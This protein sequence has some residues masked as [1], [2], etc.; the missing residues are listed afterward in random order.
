[1][2]KKMHA[3]EVNTDVYLVGRMLREQFPQWADLSIEPVSTAGTDNAL[4]RL[5]DDLV[6]RLPRTEKSAEQ[7][8][9]EQQWLP[10]LAQHLPLA[11]PVPLAKG[12]PTQDYPW[13]WSV[14]PWLE[15]E[16]ATLDRITDPSQAAI[17]MAHFIMALQQ[18]DATD[19]P[20]PG[21]H[22]F[23]RGEPLANRD[24]KTREAIA[25]LN[26]KID[27]DA[28]TMVWEAALQ[29]P[30]WDK[31]PVWIHGDLYSGNML[32]IDGQLSAV[33]DFGGL[34]VGDPA[35]DLLVAWLLFSAEMR[36]IFR[37]TLSV[38]DA[39]WARGRGWALN[40]GVEALPYY[41]DANPVLADIARYAIDGV[42][43]DP[44]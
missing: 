43:A 41:E 40:F 37:A 34:G 5:G 21:A 26:G 22:N 33:I 32:A 15:G 11:I 12:S 3:N 38:D 13:H 18:I 4:Y 28:A 7:V 6:V 10:K 29:T 30:V 36:N 16:N 35:C 20:H 44:S 2:S 39:T 31:P 17:D 19:G 42:L 24:A 9:K 1:M 27:T 25:A 23:G 14:C 8:G